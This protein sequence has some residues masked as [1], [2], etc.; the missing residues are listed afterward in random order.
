MN[1]VFLVAIILAMA[2]PV[3]ADVLV[4]KDG[5]KVIGKVTE[6]VDAYE[7]L[8]EGQQL[9]YSKDEVTRWVR[10][11]KEI[12]GDADRL[13]EEAK[14]IYKEAVE[15]PDLKEA[16]KKFRE[17]L[18]KV[19]KAREAYAEAR[20]LFPEG[21]SEL[22]AQLVNIMKLMRLVRERIGSEIA[23]APAVAKPAPPP[24][25]ATAP[26]IPVPAP[27]AAPEPPKD[28][29]A[30]ALAVL[31]DPA[32][33]ADEKAR[34]AARD[35]FR[36]AWEAGGPGSDA[37]SAGC[38]FLS[39]DDKD[40]KLVVD[41]VTVKGGGSQNTYRGKLSRKSPELSVLAL[42]GRREVR[43]RKGPDG[44]L[45]TPPGGSEFP[46]EECLI[47]TDQKSEA[48]Q[49]LQDFFSGLGA[50]KLR[51]LPDKDVLHAIAAL[52]RKTREI[53][54]RQPDAPVEP[55]RLFVGAFS[56]ALIARAGGKADPALESVF[57][58]MG[59]EK[60]EFGA[61]WGRRSGLAMDDFKKWLASGEYG[62][63]VVQFARDYAGLDEFPI[64]YAH[65]LLLLFKAVGDNRYYGRVASHFELMARAAQTAAAREHLT[66]MARSIRDAAPC[67]ACGG[68]HQVNCTACKGKKK[69]NMECGTCG[70]SGKVQTFNGVQNCRG[71][72]GKGRWDNADCPKCKATGK[73]ECRA[74][75]CTKAMEAP[76]FESFAAATL[77]PACKG[78]GT[79]LRHVALPCTGCDGIGMTLQP[80]A[81]PT[82]TIR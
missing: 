78:M 32:R 5:R 68:T 82:K 12:V 52:S 45:V 50:E 2:A 67:M 74:R 60:S 62:L 34:A 81:D 6:K 63:A 76:R 47:E 24:K 54:G 77:C 53:A 1:R 59:Y 58:E 26:P 31:I 79:L 55:L 11:P 48:L 69:I 46:A 15:M 44:M 61:V 72:K 14:A 18:P 27:V 17:A 56:S 70:G 25:P 40:W 71:C 33:R 19:V 3:L 51:T 65:G 9:V 23:S 28:G 13:V 10:S 43:I 57:K 29:L 8:V 38:L 73:A 39:Q 41:A 66:S 30:G 21:Y 4:L 22:D 20:D 36:A 75:Y 16:E 64:R 80:K 7:A 35:E 37:A 42:P 49:A